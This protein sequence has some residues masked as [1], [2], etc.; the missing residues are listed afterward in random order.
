MQTTHS[1]GVSTPSNFLTPRGGSG[2]CST[3]HYLWMMNDCV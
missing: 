1:I 3:L 2:A